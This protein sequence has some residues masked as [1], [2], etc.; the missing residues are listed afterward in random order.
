MA[1]ESDKDMTVFEL[2][3]ALL[4]ASPAHPE[5]VQGL[6][7]ARLVSVPGRSK[8]RSLHFDSYRA[9]AGDGPF[10]TLELHIPKAR[11]GISFR[12][13]L[14][15]RPT[16]DEILRHFGRLKFSEYDADGKKMIAQHYKGQCM[17]WVLD[18]QGR[19]ERLLIQDGR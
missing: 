16:R 17:S 4:H 6:I 15:E 11:G 1:T 8:E 7:G 13:V 14:R 18:D 2:A 12:I 10:T 5:R 3:Q 19:A 9:R